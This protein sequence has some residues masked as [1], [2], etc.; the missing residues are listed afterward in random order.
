MRISKVA[1]ALQITLALLWCATSAQAGEL[2]ILDSRGL[3]RSLKEIRGSA[4][5]LVTLRTPSGSTK[6]VLSNVNG[7]S[8]DINGREVTSQRLQFDNVP[9]G[10]WRIQATAGVA[11]IQKVEIQ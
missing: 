6:L 10:E 8:P 11:P 7:L 9:E 5:V 4:T 3:I 1:W 2:K